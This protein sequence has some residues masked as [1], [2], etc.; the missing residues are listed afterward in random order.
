MLLLSYSYIGLFF[1]SSHSHSFIYL[2]LYLYGFCKST[3]FF[4]ISGLIFFLFFILLSLLV[5]YFRSV[6]CV[7]KEGIEPRYGKPSPPEQTAT[8]GE[9][10]LTREDYENLCSASDEVTVLRVEIDLLQKE[11]ISLNDYQVDEFRQGGDA[12]GLNYCQPCLLPRTN[13]YCA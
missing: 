3:I 8:C 13:H 6:L 10:T 1:S 2:L 7:M 11:I 4:F 12:D 5:F 9:I